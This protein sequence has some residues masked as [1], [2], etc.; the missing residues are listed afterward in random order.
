MKK[1]PII[2]L[3]LSICLLLVGCGK[4]EEK[5]FKIVA[6]CYPVYIST[7]NI[8][9]DIP[10]VEVVNMCE[11]NVGCLHNF[12]L[13]SEDLKKIEKSS[14][15]VINGAGMESFL[16]K[17]LE[18]L[19]KVQIIDSSSGIELLEEEHE[20]ECSKECHHHHEYNPHIWMSVSNYIKQ[21]EN[22]S[23]NLKRIDSVHS[24]SYERNARLYIDKLQ[25]LKKN[26]SDRLSLV[27][28]KNII[29]FHEAF[30]YFAKEFG[31]NIL[32]VINQHPEEEPDMK[33][34]KEIIQ[35]I[36]Q[37]DIKSVFAE[38]QYPIETVNIIASETNAKVYTLDS[39]VTGE[40]DA[41]SYLNAMEE[42]LKVL[43]E[44]LK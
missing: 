21:V 16:D 10:G 41:N 9:K 19:P 4:V 26:I 44:A 28:N 7:L 36:K 32:G 40:N 30:S 8:V 29:T 11:N 25:N 5:N 27:Q 24:E 13:K 3:I 18:E 39:A 22:I 43:T 23:E 6:S 1:C 20:H 37:N 38:T 15:F 35:V 31:L 33:D 42:N 14:V 12:Q 34:I 2:L 17:I